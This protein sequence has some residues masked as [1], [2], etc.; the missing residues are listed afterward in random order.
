M[1]GVTRTRPYFPVRSG[2]AAADPH[3]RGS[4]KG[5]IVQRQIEEFSVAAEQ[6]LLRIVLIAG[7]ALLRLGFR[8]MLAGQ[9]DLE[10]VGEAADARSGF[11]L[12]EGLRPEVVAID[13][14]LPGM[15]GIAATRELSWRAP[16]SRVLLFGSGVRERDVLEGLAAGAGGFA[17][18]GEDVESLLR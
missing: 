9:S 15:S 10:L 5:G 11:P 2:C 6:G 4:S 17:L 18:K 12:V 16:G 13:V 3:P 8:S 1:I 7:E 14:A